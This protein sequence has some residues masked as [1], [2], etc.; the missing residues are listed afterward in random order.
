MFFRSI[1]SESIEVTVAMPNAVARAVEM[2]VV[3]G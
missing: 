1:A 3:N 2:A